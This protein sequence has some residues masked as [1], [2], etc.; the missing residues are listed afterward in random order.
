MS[1]AILKA[2]APEVV[3]VP[4]VPGA[5]VR[6]LAFEDILTLGD[7]ED[8]ARMACFFLCDAEGRRVLDPSNPDDVAKMRA[9]GFRKTRAILK[10]GQDLQEAGADEKKA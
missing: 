9:A 8:K 7:L 5:Y 2:I 3:P 4:G 6:E 1:D 10:A